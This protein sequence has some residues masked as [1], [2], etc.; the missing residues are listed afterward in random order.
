MKKELF[1][2]DW[3]MDFA[4]GMYILRIISNLR[5]YGKIASLLTRDEHIHENNEWPSHCVVR[6]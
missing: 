3:Q 5:E 6:T 4:E 2:V 1:T